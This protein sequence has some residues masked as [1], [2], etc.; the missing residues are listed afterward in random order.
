MKTRESVD[1]VSSGSTDAWSRGLLFAFIACAVAIPQAVGAKDTARRSA[2]S[3]TK[4]FVVTYFWNS[5]STAPNDCPEGVAQGP[6]KEIAIERLPPEQREEYRK[7]DQKIM[8]IIS[9]RG[10]HGENVCTSPTA[11]PDPGFRVAQGGIQDGL[12]LEDA[13]GPQPAQVCKHVELTSPTGEKG[14]DNQLSRVMGCVQHRR[15]DG[16]FPKY[17]V[18]QM[19]SGEY[20]YLI[21]ITGI[22]DERNDP[23]VQVGLYA[24]ADP[25]VLDSAGKVLSHASMEITSDPA[26]RHIL[27][28]QI[29]DGVLTT[30]P[31]QIKL[32]SGSVFPP[33]E[34][35]SA[36]LRLSLMPDDKVE[37]VLGGYQDWRAYYKAN[38][39]TG[40][41]SEMSGGPF[42]CSG[43][44][45]AL[46]KAAD[47]YPD[48]Q[49]GECAAISSAYKIEAIHA[50][51]IHPKGNEGK[52]VRNGE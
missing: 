32:P 23:E 12:N 28:G 44:Y 43:L 9:N 6:D 26:Y 5:I 27:R 24:S 15:A 47:A 35:R 7:S 20:A 33:L 25:M 42:Q 4:S 21:E 13:G 22:D 19:R 48:S 39:S 46:Q 36:R 30:Q 31:A 18:N 1:D 40:G 16:F 8:R 52:T 29:K 50:F 45:Y 34:L 10:P 49:T 38:V 51:V 41:I 14:I 2:G 17:F 11:L 37:G 3:G